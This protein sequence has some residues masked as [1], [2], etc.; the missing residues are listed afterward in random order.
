MKKPSKIFWKKLLY[1]FGGILI[2]LLVIDYIILPLY[3]SGSEH[4]IPN[5]IGKQK[6]EAIKIL[7]DA[8]LNPIIQTSRFDQK[9]QRDHV[10]FQN[11][12]PNMAVKT[13]RRVYLTISGGD[14]QIKMPSLVG[15]TI[16]D[17]TVTLERLGLSIGKVDSVESEFPA[18]IIVEQQFLQGKEISK[19][20]AVNFKLSIGPQVGMVRV[21]SL[22]GQTL[23][24][25]EKILKNN[26]LRVGNKVYIFSQNYLPNTVVD[27]YPSINTLTKIGDSVTVTLTRTK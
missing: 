3:V 17:A 11:P 12:S 15:K 5:V 22:F 27:Q 25:A 26:S 13:N 7:E 1:V 14:P 20:S 24:E 2:F 19:G 9:Y 4:Q 8:G 16:R 21:P 6:D 23:S 18:G 10:I